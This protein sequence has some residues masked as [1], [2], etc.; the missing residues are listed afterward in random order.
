MT[1]HCYCALY[2]AALVSDQFALQGLCGFPLLQSRDGLPELGL[3]CS[4]Y[5]LL[6]R[7][8][9]LSGCINLAILLGPSLVC[10]YSL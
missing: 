5:P 1:I 2:R 7:Y 6:T 10:P 4:R 9:G 3:L 8:D